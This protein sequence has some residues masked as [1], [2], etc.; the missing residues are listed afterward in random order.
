MHKYF[1]ASLGLLV[2]LSRCLNSREHWPLD[3]RRW[4]TAASDV[5]L[6]FD[7]GD[8]LTLVILGAVDI[9]HSDNKDSDSRVF[10][11]FFLLAN[12]S[13]KFIQSDVLVFIN[14]SYAIKVAQC[15][16]THKMYLF[17]FGESHAYRWHV[18]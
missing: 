15:A 6:S 7:P 8:W 10:F 1:A 5:T 3:S 17:L 2:H 18:C 13:W 16:R 9:A 12:R 11:F 4:P 14:S